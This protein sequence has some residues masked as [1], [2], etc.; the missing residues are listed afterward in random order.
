MNQLFVV[1]LLGSAVAY[2]AETTASVDLV[3]AYVFRGVTYNDGPCLQPSV[4]TAAGPIT[5]S[6]WANF[7]L[8]DCAPVGGDTV[9]AGD[10][11]EVD[12]TLSYGATVGGVEVS[13]GVVQ[14]VIPEAGAQ[15]NT[16]ESFL[17]VAR[18]VGA[19]V[20]LDAYVGYDFDL[21]DDVYAALG[22]RFRVPLASPEIT[23]SFSAGW[24]GEKAAQGGIAGFQEYEARAEV[25]H[26]LS[27]T[28]HL[29]AF[30]AS[31]GA[32]NDEVL[33]HQDVR[34]LGGVRLGVSL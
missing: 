19:G 1:V 3:S 25:S 31:T 13:L 24:A 30:V 7:D 33:P 21:V 20:C 18:S 27:E 32:L 29:G 17:R 15:A 5:F 14:F 2:C 22:A 26:A 12:L 11:S 34:V 23:L 4:E 6:V 28:V 9:E 16:R 8:V 10:V